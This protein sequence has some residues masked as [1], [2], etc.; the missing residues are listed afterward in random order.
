MSCKKGINSQDYA[1]EHI[2]YPESN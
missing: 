2:N 1:I